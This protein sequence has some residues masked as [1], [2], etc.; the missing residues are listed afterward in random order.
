MK[1][2]ILSTLLFMTLIQAKDFNF[3]YQFSYG[4]GGDIVIDKKEDINAGDGMVYSL[5]VV[6]NPFTNMK[7]LDTTLTIGYSFSGSIFDDSYYITKIP[8]TLTE[9]YTFSRNWRVGAGVT[10]HTNHKGHRGDT[11]FSN[12][13]F[14]DAIGGVFSLGYLFGKNKE[15]SLAFKTTIIDYDVDDTTFNGNR[16]A[17]I[18]ERRF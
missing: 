2:T 10:Y 14:D 12:L 17:L 18:L 3:L 13:K 9:H 15:T 5:G 6:F 7:N 11:N 8:I 4:F 16:F 1:K